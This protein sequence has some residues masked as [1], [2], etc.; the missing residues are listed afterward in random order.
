MSNTLQFTSEPEYKSV[1][2]SKLRALS[3]AIVTMCERIDALHCRSSMVFKIEEPELEVK[4][5]SKK[6]DGTDP[7]QVE[8]ASD[9]FIAL[10]EA[11][12]AYKD[13][14][15]HAGTASKNTY[16]IPGYIH[17]DPHDNLGEGINLLVHSLEGISQLK[18]DIAHIFKAEVLCDDFFDREKFF[19]THFP[20]LIK[21]QVTRQIRYFINQ[22]ITSMD[23]HWSSK[24]ICDKTD[25][26]SVLA[27]IQ[28]IA[29]RLSKS[30]GLTA[31]TENKL[32]A[33]KITKYAV[34]SLPESVALR[35]RRRV[36]PQPSLNIRPTDA[37]AINLAC[38]LPVIIIDSAFKVTGLKPFVPKCNSEVK[39]YELIDS[40]LNLF[41]KLD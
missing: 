34:E 1:I 15:N 12:R 23:F 39:G 16:R 28:R 38:P 10:T 40:S 31:R 25:Q 14:Y 41:R 3:A 5:T 9:S 18:E 33:L 24:W 8:F 27:K 30:S 32:E 7:I 29:E 6:F 35:Y 26:A 19:L 22:S 2:E 21:L 13:F 4:T 36:P 17:V 20:H 11:K 37:K